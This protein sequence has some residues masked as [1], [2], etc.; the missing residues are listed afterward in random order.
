MYIHKLITVAAHFFDTFCLLFFLYLFQYRWWRQSSLLSKLSHS[1]WIK[2]THIDNVPQSVK[3]DFI[4]KI[5]W[6]TNTSK[7]FT[8]SDLQSLTY[9]KKS[10]LALIHLNINTLQFHFDEL[11]LFLANCPI[12]FQIL[13]IYLWTCAHKISQWRCS[14]L[15]QK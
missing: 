4:H 11:E 8:M 14:A 9:N 10:D 7:Y 2:F 15:H 1:F 6:E 3:E 5:T 12:D 13:G